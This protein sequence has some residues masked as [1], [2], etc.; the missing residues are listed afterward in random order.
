VLFF[1]RVFAT[2]A[3]TRSRKRYD[4][5]TK[6]K[7]KSKIY[8]VEIRE[9]ENREKWGAT[10]IVSRPVSKEPQ[11]GF[12]EAVVVSIWQTCICIHSNATDVALQSLKLIPFVLLA[13]YCVNWNFNSVWTTCAN[14][15]HG[16][17]PAHLCSHP[18]GPATAPVP[19]PPD[20]PSTCA[21]VGVSWLRAHCATGVPRCWHC[22]RLPLSWP[23]FCLHAKLH[24]QLNWSLLMKIATF[25]KA[26]SK[27]S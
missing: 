2:S 16:S 24:C 8:I 23:A 1:T 11:N 6:K 18:S 4:T 10:S 14:T 21:D 12:I 15:W 5:Q 17:P 13:N 25:F 27:P 20:C 19:P 9:C 26:L 3:G 22:A 7:R